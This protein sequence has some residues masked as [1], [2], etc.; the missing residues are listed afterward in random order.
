MHTTDPDVAEEVA[1]VVS[2]A[3]AIVSQD[4]VPQDDTPLKGLI[5]WYQSM[6]T[7]ARVGF[8]GV[9]LIAL[10]WTWP[11]IDR[12]RSRRPQ[13]LTVEIAITPVHTPAVDDSP[14]DGQPAS[15][16]QIVI[17]TPSAESDATAAAATPTDESGAETVPLNDAGSGAP[18]A[19]RPDTILLIDPLPT[20]VAVVLV[21]TATPTT[22]P[23]TEAA[24]VS[25]LPQVRILPAVGLKLPPTRTP[26][27][28]AIVRG[29]TAT[30][31]PEP[32]PIDPGRLWSAFVPLPA[33]E[34][35][36]FWVGR[37]LLPSAINQLSSPSYQFGSSAGDRYRPH[38][39]VDISNPM[40]TPVLAAT[41]G[42]VVHAGLDDPELLGPYNNFYGNAVVIRL[43]RKLTVG[44]G[45]L[46]VYLL[47]GHLSQ[48]YATV[49]QQVKPDDVV[50][51]VGMTG[52][53]IG[54]HLHVEMRLGANTYRHSVNPYL[55]LQPMGDNGAVAVRLLTADG[56]T[57]PGARLTLAR[58]ES[59]Q[60]TWARLIETYLDTE[61]IGPDPAWGEN[62]AM[63]GVPGGYYVLVGVVNGES[64]RAELTVNPGQTSFIEIRTRQ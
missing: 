8:L 61:N 49:G 52:I 33:S 11:Q 57:W 46:D 43:N 22:L 29:P 35:D 39:G 64:V 37:P 1:D 53:A 24:A 44:E 12:D 3:P 25:A 7:T 16:A 23:S 45:E 51:A 21:P 30:P 41:E 56:R 28:N 36:H 38:H 58:F 63:E 54:P 14:S 42:E 31:T 32:L 10:W 62:G 15:L 20:K 40:G 59:G 2:V 17:P 4:I 19:A 13:E 18:A 9:A 47:Y 26:V 60:A 5:A 27:G 34:S 48:V 55:W 50:G 6:P